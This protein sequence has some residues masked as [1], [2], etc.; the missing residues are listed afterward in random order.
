MKDGVVRAGA[1]VHGACVSVYCY[2]HGRRVNFECEREESP[3][4]QRARV[5]GL[6]WSCLGG[7][8]INSVVNHQVYSPVLR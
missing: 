7:Y 5:K 2:S 4:S 6:I 3:N 8:S 1:P